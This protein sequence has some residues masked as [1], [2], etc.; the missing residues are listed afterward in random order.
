M[1][2]GLPGAVKIRQAMVA[3]RMEDGK[4]V[5][6]PEGSIV[7]PLYPAADQDGFDGHWAC[8]IAATWE[9][10]AIPGEILASAIR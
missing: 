1:P 8:E 5:N 7:A 3:Q 10:V 6:M 4:P 2:Y 9:T